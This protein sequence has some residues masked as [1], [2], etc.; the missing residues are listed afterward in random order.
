MLVMFDRLSSL[1]PGAPRFGPHRVRLF[2]ERRTSAASSRRLPGQ[3]RRTPT[4]G[5]TGRADESSSTSPYAC[6]PLASEIT[7]APKSTQRAPLTHLDLG[8]FSRGAALFNRHSHVRTSFRAP[9]LP[10]RRPDPARLGVLLRE[11]VDEGSRLGPHTAA[12]SLE[13]LLTAFARLVYKTGLLF[14]AR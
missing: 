6:T 5:T 8:R 9:R 2:G 10:S 14:G 13:R 1:F 7:P 4:A 12:H 3:T 11:R